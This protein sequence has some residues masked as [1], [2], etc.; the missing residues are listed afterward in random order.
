MGVVLTDKASLAM[1]TL[2]NDSMLSISNTAAGMIDGDE[3]AGLDYGCEGTPEYEHVRDTLTR[4]YKNIELEDIYCIKPESGRGFV[5]VMDLTENSPAQFGDSVKEPTDA[6]RNAAQGKS[7]VDERP[8]EDRWGRFYSAYSPVLDSEGN[9]AGIIAVDFDANWYDAQVRSIQTTAFYIGLM[10]LLMG[11][12]VVVIMTTSTRS[13]L[14]HAHDQLNELSDNVEELIM[15]V[16]N[17]SPSDINPEVKKVR[18]AYE[19]DGLDAPGEKISNMQTA[20]K[21][22]IFHIK[23]NAFIDGMTGA[24]NRN[25]YL[26]DVKIADPDIKEGRLTFAVAVFDITGLKDINDTQGH[27]CGD[28]AIADSARILRE[29]FGRDNLYRTGGD[30]FVAAVRFATADDMKKSFGRI[31]ALQKAVNREGGQY[32]AR[33]LVLSKGYAVF[34]P[35]EDYEFMDTFRRADKRMYDDKAAFYKTHDRRKR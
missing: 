33:P 32:K 2:M 19:D 15:E 13:R 14:K 28:R 3:L 34:D 22:Q 6:L 24:K 10:S 20:L 16:G 35:E 7:A 12:V 18:M 8:Y 26:E 1:R 29:V 21:E 31:E 9:V 17:L 25:A 23:E 4:F 11:A 27:E 5:F 30:E